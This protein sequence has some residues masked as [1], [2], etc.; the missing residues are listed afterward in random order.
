MVLRE[1]GSGT[2]QAMLESLGMKH[3]EREL[4]VICH[5]GSEYGPGDTTYLDYPG[6]VP[7]EG[8]DYFCPD[9]GKIDL[10]EVATVRPC[11]G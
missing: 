4:N 8:N 10:I 11:D 5:V 6:C 7:Y 2:R 9:A 3:N 1:E